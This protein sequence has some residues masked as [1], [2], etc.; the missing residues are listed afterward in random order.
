MIILTRLNG[1]P[2]AIN[3]DH[4]ERIDVTPDT[5]VTLL[6]GNKY[7]VAETLAEVISK[8][9]TYRASVISLATSVEEPTSRA[10]RLVA[11]HED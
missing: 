3:P 1:Q 5:I 7:V 4:I 9:R 10:L 6:E 2:F 8:V 11:N